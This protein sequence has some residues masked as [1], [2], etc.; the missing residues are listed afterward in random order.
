MDDIRPKQPK[1]QKRRVSIDGVTPLNVSGRTGRMDFGR[2]SSYRPNSTISS[3]DREEGIHHPQANASLGADI[4]SHQPARKSFDPPKEQR[5]K[6]R[7]GLFKNR[8]KSNKSL[9]QRWREHSKKQKIARILVILLVIL[10]LIGGFLFAKGYLN[11]RKILGGDGGAAA[12]QKD[13]DPSKLNGE[14]DGRV[15][16]LLLGRGGEGHDGADLTD[17]MIVASINPIDKEAAL[18]SIPRDLYVAVPNKGSM[19]INAVFSAGKSSVLNKYS[20]PNA[21]VRN[22]ADQEGFNL[23]ED[24]VEKVLGIPIHYHVMVDFAG[25][26]QAI[27]TV[28]G[29]DLN[30]PSAVKEQ[31]W[32]NGRNYM[33]DVKPGQQHM[34]GFKALAY[35]RS[36]H[37]SAR[38]DFDRSE[39]Q[40]II[41]VAL[42][43]KVLSLGTFSNPAKVS[44]LLDNLGS[45]V[46]TNF[47]LQDIGR[48]YDISKEIPS[49]KVQSIGLVD[50]PHD[51]LTTSSIGGLSVVVPKAGLNNY[52]DIQSFIRNTLK[53]SFIKNENASVMVLNGTRV[54]GLATAKA[55]ELKSYGYNVTDVANAPTKDYARTIVVDMRG[56]SK[57]Y[58]KRYLEQRFKTIATSNLP[59]SNIN[60]GNADFV[61]ILGADQGAS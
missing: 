33:L 39:R 1:K 40:R 45:H 44:S 55:D 11:L 24:M 30:A 38:G 6:K 17:T 41:L 9:L 42:K 51:Y 60:S 32:I 5:S 36:R 54:P 20:K 53:D 47:S 29:I 35:S 34:D 14:G 16:I 61:I 50:P 12:L 3:F 27:N 4:Q 37:T 56:G 26:E 10:A 28:G 18:V 52:K 2:P 25:F 46:Q 58:T 43:D 15:N 21:D 49:N 22:Q 13:V 19:K 23:T 31:M 57:K 7:I 59:D 8:K 48:L